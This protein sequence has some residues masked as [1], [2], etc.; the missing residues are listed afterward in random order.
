MWSFVNPVHIH[1][2]LSHAPVVMILIGTGLLAWGTWTRSVELG[3]GGL[4]LL[5]LACFV[6][7]PLYLT[8]EPSEMPLKDCPAF[9]I[10]FWININH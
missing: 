8:G 3:R 7:V 2:Y 4:G 5:I 10:E 1:L 9:P 6:I